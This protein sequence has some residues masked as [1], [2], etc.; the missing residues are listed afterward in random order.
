MIGLMP[1]ARHRKSDDKPMVEG[2][3][4][5][6]VKTKAAKSLHWVIAFV[7][8]NGSDFGLLLET[9]KPDCAHH[10]TTG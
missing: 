10:E 1:K 4:I 9:L 6:S 5:Q 7:S 2:Q 8:C 3:P